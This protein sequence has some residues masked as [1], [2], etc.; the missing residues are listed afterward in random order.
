MAAAD[1]GIRPREIDVFEDTRPRRHRRERLMRLHAVLVE[2]HHFAVLHV[3]HVLRADDVER[4]GLRG[5]NRAAVELADHQRANAE[6]RAR[7]TRCR[8]TSVSVVDC[9]MAPSCTRFLRSAMPLVRLP[10]WPMAKPPPSSSANSGCTLR[11]T[12]SPVVE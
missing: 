2:D 11:S 5:Q 4:A 8:I 9:I 10:L 6:W 12:V 1:D 7:A 3:A